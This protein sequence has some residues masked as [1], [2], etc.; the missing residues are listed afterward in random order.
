MEQL[1]N[2]IYIGI[3]V[4]K[5]KL[6]IKYDEKSPVLTIDNDKK[7]FKILNQYFPSDKQ[8][9]LVV[10]EST[11]GYEKLIVKW[12][13]SKGIPVAVVNAKRVR[14]YAKATGLFAKTD[15]L[16]AIVI[17][18][19]A[20]TFAS[21]VHLQEMKGKLEEQIEDLMR[22]KKQMV[23]LRTKEKQHLSITQNTEIKRSITRAI[24][25]YSHEID[26]IAEK[27]IQIAAKDKLTQ[28]KINLLTSVKGVGLDTAF[29]LIGELPEL[30]QL[31]KNQITA[32]V[33][34]APFCR[35]S[36]RMKGK[37]T[38]W[39]GRAQVR[40]ALYMA[41]VSARRY[42]PAIKKFYDRLI[43]QGKPVKVAMVACMR[44][45]LIVLNVMVKNNEPWDA[46]M[47]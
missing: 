14:D 16:D 29:T 21:K 28:D 30:G 17:R 42:N 8:N 33:G 9:V 26:K 43:S 2:K 31:G 39:G 4:S 47:V 35:D 3:D 32:L 34:L 44:K 23:S 37:R 13:L 5:A 7:G 12:L 25:F 38:I 10:M 27:L 15:K 11:G 24:K 22:R 20:V 46:K 45:L 40:G 36:G 6:D 19:Y 41:V 1:I 18:D